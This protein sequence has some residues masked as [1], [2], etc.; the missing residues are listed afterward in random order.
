MKTLSNDCEWS[1]R[2]PFHRR[3]SHRTVRARGRVGLLL[4]HRR[5]H[6]QAR[7]AHASPAELRLDAHR[8]VVGDRPQRPNGYLDHPHGSWL[9]G[10]DT[11]RV[12]SHRPDPDRVLRGGAEG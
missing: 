10:G 12:R 7:D 6:E 11:P 3:A 1:N 2:E 4:L 5:G 9:P 8:A